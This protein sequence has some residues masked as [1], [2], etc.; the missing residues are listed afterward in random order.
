MVTSPGQTPEASGP[1][2]PRSDGGD[3]PDDPG[4]RREEDLD[5]DGLEADL[6]TSGAGEGD[7]DPDDD[8]VDVEDMTIPPADRDG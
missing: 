2:A 4:L 6:D 3:A 7:L 5:P 8:S 1:G